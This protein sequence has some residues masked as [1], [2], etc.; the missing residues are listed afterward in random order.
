MDEK[1]K[2]RLTF[3][4]WILF[5]TLGWV[6]GFI[7]ALMIAEPLDKINLGFFGLGL[8]IV[9]GIGL[10]QWI[11]LRRHTSI[12]SRWMWL[13]IA[14]MG[15]SFLL[16]D[17]IIVILKAIG[18]K[19]KMDGAPFMIVITITV[20]IGGYVTGLLQNKLLMK[21]NYT[22]NSGWILYSFLAWTT[23][24]VFISVN[25]FCMDNIFHIA[26]TAVGKIMN[27][28]AFLLVGPILGFIS[29][30]KILTILNTPKNT[31]DN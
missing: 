1:I 6:V 26:F 11:I 4:K 17:V 7:L 24:V 27:I 10:M 29:G 19:Y 30:K 21:N 20:A 28:F 23:C 22:N 9:T 2:V 12:D 25:F 8:G 16:F 5:T 13:A 31:D 14:G 18:F 15:S 3:T